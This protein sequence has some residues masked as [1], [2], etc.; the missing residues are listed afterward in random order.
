MFIIL[1]NLKGGLLKMPANTFISVAHAT[2][3]RFALLKE[4]YVESQGKK[5]NDF[6]NLLMDWCEDDEDDTDNPAQGD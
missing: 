1:Q 2:K 6:L 3:N 4:E 5:D